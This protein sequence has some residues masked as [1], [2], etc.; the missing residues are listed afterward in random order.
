MEVNDSHST[1][2]QTATDGIPDE[3]WKIFPSQGTYVKKIMKFSGYETIDS[4]L[5]LKSKDEIEKMFSFVKTMADVVEEKDA[6]FGIFS[7]CPEK[8]M[9][10]PGL[11]VRP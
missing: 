5:K 7:K 2:S 6:M 4:V 1:D 11:E 8:V 3:I 10:L 9:L